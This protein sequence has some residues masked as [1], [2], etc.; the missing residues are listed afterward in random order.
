MVAFVD[1]VFDELLAV[2]LSAQI[3]DEIGTEI[4]CFFD[5]VA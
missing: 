2:R 5:G 1:D 3:S 4:D